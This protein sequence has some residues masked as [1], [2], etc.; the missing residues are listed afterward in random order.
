MEEMSRPAAAPAVL[1]FL[2]ADVRG[3]T[4]FTRERGDAA[5]AVLAKRFADLSREAVEARGGRVIEL[6]GDEALA[7]FQS[8]D[9]AIRAAV[10]LQATCAEETESDPAL[11]LPVGIGI[12]TGAAEPV[13]DGYRGVAL[14]MAARLCSQA[15]AGE[16]LVTARVAAAF[17]EGDELDFEERGPV[18]LKGFEQPVDV[19]GVKAPIEPAVARDQVPRNDERLPPEFDLA[20]P[21]IG[22]QREMQWLIGTWRYVRRGRGRLLFVSGEAQIGKTRLAAEFGTYAFDGGGA[23][24][25]AG[26]GGAATALALRAI[27]QAKASSE[28][29]LL[30]IDDGDVAGP[31]VARAL[32]AAM[33]EIANK[34]VLILTLLRDAEGEHELSSVVAGANERGDGH[35]KLTPFDLDQVREVVRLY[36]GEDVADAPI[37][38]MERSSGGVP[39]RIHEV[40][41]DWARSE[42]GRRLEA[43]AE[44]LTA[45]RDKRADDLEFA[46]N[47]I[48]LK[49]GRLYTVEGR[50][51]W[52]V[53][54]AEGECPYKGLASFQ[55]GDSA[56]FFGRERLVGELAARI[57]GVGLLGVIGASGSGKSSVVAAGLLP[58]LR[59]G[60]LPGSERW[61]QV[62]MRPG[63]RPMTALAEAVGELEADAMTADDPLAELAGRAGER[64]VLVVD[65]FE[66]VFTICGDERERESFLTA[67]ASAA[68]TAPERLVVIP[69]IRSDLYGNSA[70]YEAFAELMS[71]NHVLVAPMT[72]DEIRRA[73]ELPARR[74]GLRVEQALVDALVEEVAD[75]PG[76]LPLLSTAMVELWGVRAEGWIRFE[77]Y[78]RTGGVRGAVARLA[79]AAYLALDDAQKEAAR[80][81]FLRLVAVEGDTLARRRVSLEEFDLDRDAAAKIA[82]DRLVGDRLLTLAEDSVEVAHEALL[83]EWPRL[84]AWLEE[85]MQG[86]QLRQHLT[87]AARQWEAGGREPSELYRGARLSAT[88]DWSALR[89]QELNTLEQEF[90]SESRQASALDAQRQRRTNRRLRGLLVAVGIFLVVALGAGALALVQRAN[91]QQ[92]ADEAVRAARVSLA[93]SLGAQAVS[94][95]RLDLAMLLAREGSA[96]DDSVRTRSNLMTT[97]LKEPTV[98][99]VLHATENRVNGLGL[100]PDGRRLAI[101]DNSGN[102]VVVD[103]TTGERIGEVESKPDVAMGPDGAVLRPDY[104]DGLLVAVDAIDPRTGERAA[105]FS[106]PKRVRKAMAFAREEDSRQAYAY[107]PERDRLA[108]AFVMDNGDLINDPPEEWPP[109]RIVQW[110]YGTGKLT[111]KPIPI[112]HSILLSMDYAANG[113][114]LVVLGVET[115]IFSAASGRLLRS[116]PTG[117]YPGAVSS[118]G[119]TAALGSGN[120]VTFID[121]KSGKTE[122]GTSRHAQDVT[123]LGYTPDGQTLI[124][125]SDDGKTFLWDARSHDVEQTLGGHAGNVHSQAIS[126]DGTALYTGGFDTTVLAYDLGGTESFVR[127]FQAAD[128]DVNQ[129]AWNLA[130]SPDSR[131][132]AVGDTEGRVNLWDAETL[133]KIRTFKAVPGLV[134]ALSFA[135]DGRSLLVAGGSLEPPKAWL[136]MWD[137]EGAPKLLQEMEPGID[138]LTWATLSPDGKTVA[139]TGRDADGDLATGGKV[140][141]WDAATGKL[142]APPMEIDRG[143]PVHVTFG[144]TGTMV[145]IAAANGGTAIVDPARNET[146]KEWT[147]EA[148]YNTTVAFSPDGD[149]LATA[150]FNGLV[151]IWDW[152]AGEGLQPE[153]VGA[154]IEASEIEVS[155]VAWMPDGESIVSVGGETLRMYD[156][157]SRRQI[158][159]SVPVSPLAPYVATTAD[160]EAVVADYAGRAWV[161]PL[162]LPDWQ[163]RACTVANRNFTPDEWDE[164]VVGRPHEDVCP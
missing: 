131:T 42:A 136:R 51:A 154:P 67:L 73:V 15:S 85:D 84:Q 123:A 6:R 32:G 121:L 59:A 86:R 19:I 56:T 118:D 38:S 77:A 70:P 74:V 39:G 45:G 143:G 91:A 133:E 89:A 109:A 78:E 68:L 33:D 53:D 135:P 141:E 116:F 57:V 46:N 124:S 157:E 29:T 41:S 140:A 64:V 99:M 9:Q 4:K 82:I 96:L 63:E 40:A 125:S 87:Q 27:E 28:P 7:V 93:E 150:D 61:R 104:E 2:I 108:V 114:Q 95:P 106:V 17:G 11:P 126:P 144:P 138:V 134:V 66:E 81:V 127:T 145:A 147:V 139:A 101:A 25:Y 47:V 16:V 111:G 146:L 158:G 69:T 62:T 102:A 22:R 35:R 34:P 75:E 58:S 120:S 142:L 107:D 44:Y 80:R 13:E 20:T 54:L 72:R 160:G 65:Q 148:I 23:V 83:R 137:I 90:L 18:A 3:Y 92:S 152:R 117:G 21:L 161:M 159:V 36:A 115:S 164:F 52:I 1:T 94:Q 149:L 155:G 100:S 49:L 5:A 162:S 55:E 112:E 119:S 163:E 105:S 14:N 43:A 31:E 30:V 113:R 122:E 97:L 79:E 132:I 110:D 8:P 103:T 76:G 98:R 60:L 26:P 153:E 130:V 10:E 128:T 12:D 129:G 50:D 88:L 151:R 156:V 48:R 37:E 24:R 71:A